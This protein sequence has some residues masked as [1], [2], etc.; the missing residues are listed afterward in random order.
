[1]WTPPASPTA[2]A[3]FPGG[4]PLSGF[5]NAAPNFNQTSPSNGWRENIAANAVDN[6]ARLIRQ[7]ANLNVRIHT[8]G[9]Q[10]TD[11]LQYDVLERLANCDGC[12]RVDSNDAIDPTQAKGRFV[13]ALNQDELLSAFLDVAGFI[14]RIVE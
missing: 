14:G 4:V 6:L 11:P 10:G 12:T 13:A 1:M 3:I 8:I 7:D 9:Y 5:R 2:G